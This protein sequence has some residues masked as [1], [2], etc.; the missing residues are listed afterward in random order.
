MAPITV[1]RP[2]FSEPLAEPKPLAPRTTP[3]EPFVLGLID[4][5]KPKARELLGFIADELRS[6]GHDLEV[7]LLSK[8]GAG[9]TITADDATRMAAR[10][11]LVITGLGD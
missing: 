7:E 6:R 8:P 9:K 1:L 11:H 10:C 5:G 2:D 4:N 3:G